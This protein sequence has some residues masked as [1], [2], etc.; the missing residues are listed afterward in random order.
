MK[1][2]LAVGFIFGALVAP[3]AAADMPIKAPPPPVLYNWTGFYVGANIGGGWGQSSWCTDALRTTC[4]SGAPLDI[5]KESGGG[6][7]LGGQ[8]GARWQFS[9]WVIG[10]E[11][12]LD[13]L[14]IAPANSS[15]LS[16]PP[17][18]ICGGTV[19]LDRFRSTTFNDLYS[20]TGQLGYA[21]GTLLAYGKGGWA[22]TRINFDANNT[23]P[24]G[25]NLTSSVDVSGW[26]GGA[27]LEYMAGPHFTFGIEYDYYQF[28]H[29]NLM[30]IANTG[31]VVIPC[32]FC[33]INNTNIQTLTA[34]LNYKI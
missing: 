30:N 27:G 26:T 32:G 7:V 18:A 19:F 10:A 21:W 6:A 31:G 8:L 28:N 2:F 5:A 11:L 25:F 29:G 23:A 3:A 13:G 14:H 1:R 20:G 34:R 9:N 22:G 4:L 16:V 12:M 17:A 15:C 33:G 24:G